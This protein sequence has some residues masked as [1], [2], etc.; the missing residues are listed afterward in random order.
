M[1][2]C[3]H[4]RSD[5]S[6][7]HCIRDIV[8]LELAAHTLK[9]EPSLCSFVLIS[10]PAAAPKKRSLSYPFDHKGA[11]AGARTGTKARDYTYR[12]SAYG[13]FLIAGSLRLSRVVFL[14][15]DSK[16]IIRDSKAVIFLSLKPFGR[17]L[18]QPD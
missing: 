2:A 4:P 18:P 9:E 12:S 13:P 16:T 15:H 11:A 5:F 8:N 1:M 10:A 7:D 3:G 6:T 14:E 17:F